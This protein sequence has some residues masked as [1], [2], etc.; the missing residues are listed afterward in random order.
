M[1]WLR[2]QI[3][4]YKLNSLLGLL[5]GIGVASFC[6]LL[7][8]ILPLKLALV[9]TAAIV[10]VPLLLLAVVDLTFGL[11]LT[12]AAGFLIG[13]V[14]KYTTAPIG[15]LL[16]LLMVWLIFGLLARLVKEKAMRYVE[17]PISL[18][19]L[20]WIAYNLMQVLN[21]VAGSRMAWVYTVRSVA[22]LLMLY[23][24]ALR[25]FDT[26]AAAF[27]ALKTIIFWSFAAALY[28]LKQEFVGFSSTELAWL[29]ADELRFQLIYQWS[30]LRIFSFFSDPTTYGILM[31]YMSVVC[32]ILVAGRWSMWKRI[33][34]AAAGVSMW[35]AIAYAGSRTPVV[36]VPAGI[37]FATLLSLNRKTL[38]ISSVVFLFGAAFMSKST[39]SA[40]IYRIQSAFRPTEDAS[41]Q[42]RLKNQEKIQPF[43]RRHPF[44]AGLGSTGYWGKRFT[45]DSW[46][47]SFA[48][49]SLYVRLAVETGWVGLLLYLAL[50]FSAMQ[51]GIYWY[52]R[53][54]DPALKLVYLSL[55]C[56]VFMLALASYPQEAITLLPTSI[57]F[58]LMLALIVRLKDFDTP[59]RATGAKLK[60]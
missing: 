25:A 12:V 11:Q 40:V 28:G 2:T 33:V 56:S 30:R 57:I 15:T 17:N 38:A 14:A 10:G 34:L 42:L 58:Y 29:H 37:A 39:H 41:L 50:L 20:L 3:I 22:L 53:V 43:I 8:G 9:A 52:Y 18:F 51:Q 6:A 27:R 31:A 19:V 16:D 32:F 23:F 26:R 47:A 4:G 36:M 7:F 44:G 45:P 59:S 48:H 21:P 54:R 49:D 13:L 60:Q 1:E 55:V 24:V 5:T 35:L 46:L